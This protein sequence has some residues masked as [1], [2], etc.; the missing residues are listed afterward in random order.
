MLS[1][2]DQCSAVSDADQSRAHL[3][4]KLTSVLMKYLGREAGVIII[5]LLQNLSK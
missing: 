1:S 4:R 3:E 2:A 5:S